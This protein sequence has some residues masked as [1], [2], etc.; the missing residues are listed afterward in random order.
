[1]ISI[2][3]L[4]IYAERFAARKKGLLEK[5][6]VHGFIGFIE[7][8]QAK[9]KTSGV[10]SLEKRETTR[11]LKELKER[12]DENKRVTPEDDFLNIKD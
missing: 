4:Q 12:Q 6:T 1:M 3:E 2:A 8:E 7:A 11:R 10:I 5:D 9:S